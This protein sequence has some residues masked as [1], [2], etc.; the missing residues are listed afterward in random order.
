VS[1]I[2]SIL[3][4]WKSSTILSVDEIR[5]GRPSGFTGKFSRATVSGQGI[6][7]TLTVTFTL[8][9][10]KSPFS[11]LSPAHTHTRLVILQGGRY[12]LREVGYIESA[13]RILSTH[14]MFGW[15]TNF[16]LPLAAA[17]RH[18]A[19]LIC[20][21]LD[22]IREAE[23]ELPRACRIPLQHSTYPISSPSQHYPSST[24]FSTASTF[25][26]LFNW[27]YV[28]VSF[29]G[30]SKDLNNSNNYDGG[31]TMLLSQ[32][33]PVRVRYTRTQ[34]SPFTSSSRKLHPSTSPSLPSLLGVRSSSNTSSKVARRIASS[35]TGS[36][37]FLS[38]RPAHP[39]LSRSLHLRRVG[40]GLAMPKMAVGNSGG[41]TSGGA[42][43]GDCLVH[44]CGEDS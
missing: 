22:H 14:S 25:Y 26:Q 10:V 17:C 1:G 44:G 19:N 18:T 23:R 5:A 34:P 43:G 12:T 32:N 29:T 16:A 37:S 39:R 20:Y 4:E 33:L 3:I 27:E 11:S 35:S 13:V 38:N 2:S 28:K 15:T 21:V 40:A 6:P 36:H 24:I 41:Y 31:S 30:L 9:R 7:I 42:E 8:K